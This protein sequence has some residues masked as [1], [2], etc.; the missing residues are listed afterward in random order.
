L[1]QE[2]S[3][4]P[5]Q[6]ARDVERYFLSRGLFRQKILQDGDGRDV[7]GPKDGPTFAE[8]KNDHVFPRATLD[9]IPGPQM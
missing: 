5:A 4:N 8:N 1:D 7:V 6:T 3:G 9:F 2:K